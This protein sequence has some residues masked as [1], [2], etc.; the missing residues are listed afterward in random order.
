MSNKKEIKWHVINASLAGALVFLGGIVAGE[1]TWEL[2]GA[3]AVAGST[4]AVS[5][6][7]DYWSTQEIEYRDLSTDK[8]GELFNFL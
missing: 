2:I 8:R 4:V 7:K 5:K 1:I 6:F 3:A